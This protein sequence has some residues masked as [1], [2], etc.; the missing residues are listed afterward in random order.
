M[1]D[2][3]LR[4]LREIPVFTALAT[5]TL[6]HL[7][8]SGKTRHF[9]AHD[10]LMERGTST[11]E[12]M[13]VLEGAVE[14]LRDGDTLSL[15]APVLVG[16]MAGFTQ[17]ARAATVRAQT[18][19]TALEIERDLFLT[20]VRTSAQAAQT[21]TELVADRICAADSLQKIGRFD[22]EGVIAR[23]GSGCV[24]RAR[25]PLLEIPIALKMLSHALALSE[26]GPKDFIREASILAQ[27]E[28][29][30]IVRVLD[31]F[32]SHDT[33][34]IVM[35]WLEGESVRE[36]IDQKRLVKTHELVRWTQEALQALEVLHDVHLVHRDIKPS[37]LYLRPSGQLVLID[38]GICCAE[39]S[40]NGS[41]HLVGSPFYC[42]PEQIL[43]R[44]LDGKSDVYSLGCTLYEIIYGAPPFV[45]ES[46]EQVLDGHL[47]G[48]PRFPPLP[49]EDIYHM[50]VPWLK[51]CLRRTRTTRPSAREALEQLDGL[52]NDL[53]R[54]DKEPTSCEN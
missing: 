41:G 35:P 2:E 20:A 51:K 34:F 8:A 14:V 26:N 6:E 18:P 24:L 37:N 1:S 27:L 45:G 32:E 31:A 15:R 28:H 11:D 50:Y 13:V 43:G 53:P 48:T 54:S 33:F 40:K 17:R 22:V 10:V 42:S 5:P 19:V 30:G 12:A 25:H 36:R 7:L 47:R 23:G 52:W 29:P 49:N 21:L 3:T 44:P 46:I 9:S 39:G 16:E 4:M 38:F